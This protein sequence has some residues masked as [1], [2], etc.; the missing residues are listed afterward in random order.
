MA[1]QEKVK[2][3]KVTTITPVDFAARPNNEGGIDM[4][5]LK[6]DGEIKLAS[7]GNK[8]RSLKFWKEM[9]TFVDSIVTELEK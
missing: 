6:P 7:Q 3:G 1:D 5:L 4:V 9:K 2:I 8:E